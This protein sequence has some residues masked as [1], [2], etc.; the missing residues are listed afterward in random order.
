MKPAELTPLTALELEL[1][2]L[3]VGFPAGVLNVVA[4]TG[5][6][7]GRALVD[8]PDVAKIAFTGSTGVGK[9]IASRAAQTVK[10]VT[11]EL[12]GKSASVIF[13]DADV[14]A[15]AAAVPSSVFDNAGQDCCARSRLLVH[16]DVLDDFMNHLEV[17]VKAWRVGD[18]L[19]DRKSVV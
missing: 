2:A 3:E 10:R 15:A 1:I 6:E 14:A 8:H 13:D 7:A 5:L 18:P 16:V 19:T 17:A 9:D 11:L 12:G 4:G